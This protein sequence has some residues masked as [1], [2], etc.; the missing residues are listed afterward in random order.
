VLMYHNL[1]PTYMSPAIIHHCKG[2]PIQ[3]HAHVWLVHENQVHDTSGA[4]T[5]A[6]FYA[7]SC[8]RQHFTYTRPLP[9]QKPQQQLTGKP[10][11]TPN[12]APPTK[13]SPHPPPPAVLGV[14]CHCCHC[15]AVKAGVSAAVLFLKEGAPP[16]PPGVA[17]QATI[18][19]GGQV[20]QYFM[21][22]LRCQRVMCET[23]RVWL[24]WPHAAGVCCIRS[25]L[26]SRGVEGSKL[27]NT[28]CLYALLC[29]ST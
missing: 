16:P 4:A 27:P 28:P 9:I 13:S 21:Q 15:S 14:A 18:Q 3:R 2:V 25:V 20:M 7:G 1:A 23:V 6:S 29:H 11:G 10:S 19:V 5:A 22:T 17:A 8:S 26:L 24:P 12:P